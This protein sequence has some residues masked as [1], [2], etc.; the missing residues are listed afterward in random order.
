[1]NDDPND[2]KEQF[3]NPQSHF[4]GEFTPENLAFNANLQE[5][6]NRISIICN[7][8]TGGRISP[9]DAYK[10]IKQ[11]WKQLKQSKAELLDMP[12]PPNPD[13]PPD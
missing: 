13:L 10:E 7:L 9:E 11:L 5:F 4:R 12:K 3:L 6:A 1:M 8:E 2:L